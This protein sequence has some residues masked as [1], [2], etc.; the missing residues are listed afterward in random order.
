MVT[1]G[2]CGCH[3][4]S[5]DDAAPIDWAPHLLGSASAVISTDGGILHLADVTLT[6]PANAL[7]A[8]TMI[9]VERYDTGVLTAD[10]NAAY[11]P[12]SDIYRFLPE[13]TQFQVE[14]TVTIAT[15]LTLDPTLDTIVWTDSDDPSIYDP[16]PSVTTPNTGYAT[17]FSAGFLTK[18]K[19]VTTAAIGGYCNLVQ[20]GQQSATCCTSLHLCGPGL[21]CS[22]GLC[23]NTICTLG[24]RGS[25]NGCYPG[26]SNA[27]C[28]SNAGA[29]QTCGVGYAC[30]KGAC[31]LQCPQGQYDAGDCG[32]IDTNLQ[33]CLGVAIDQSKKCCDTSVFCNTG[34]FAIQSATTA[35]GYQCCTIDASTDCGPGE[36]L[37]CESFA[38]DDNCNQISQACSCVPLDMSSSLAAC[39]MRSSM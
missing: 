28:G 16:L 26:N 1:I 9:T 12:E 10:Q 32:C 18:L 21:T 27:Y 19:D 8:P 30:E 6:I 36:V 38:Y 17:H 25:P 13:G 20:H 37:R 23:K 5:S 15:T 31:A 2:M 33:C 34:Q 24:C 4:A 35:S 29:C 3:A 39:D 11:A 14:T 7:A 22:D